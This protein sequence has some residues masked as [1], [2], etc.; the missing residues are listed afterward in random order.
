MG[1]RRRRRSPRRIIT[2]LLLKPEEL[3][4]LN[5]VLQAK[6]HDI[7]KQE[8]R[9]QKYMLEDAEF[10][11]V[12]FGTAARVSLTAVK[13]ARQRGIRIGLFRPISL[14]PFPFA[15][16]SQ[17]SKQLRAVLVVRNERRADGSGCAVGNPRLP[18]R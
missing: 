10:A 11:I 1:G 4:N 13:W 16:L 12:A 6:Q 17:V 18:Y 2:S 7:E 14:Y 9:F 8:T 5:V 15:Q 3:E